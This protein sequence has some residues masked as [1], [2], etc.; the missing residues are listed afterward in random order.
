ML[1]NQ[2]HEIFKNSNLKEIINILETNGAKVRLV[3]GIVRDFY[4]NKKLN[5]I[6]DIDLVTNFDPKKVLEI[7]EKNNISAFLLNENYGTVCIKLSKHQYEITSLRSDIKN[8]GR[9]AKIQIHDDW[10]LD[11][12]RR[13]FTF[14]AI[15]LDIRGNKFDPFD[16]IKD[17]ENGIV[18]FIGDP[19]LRIQEDYLRIL[20]YVRF[21]A[22]YSK[23]NKNNII[24]NILK[25]YVSKI[26]LLSLE[27]ITKEIKL[28]FSLP[29]IKFLKALNVM[30]LSNIAYAIFGNK[31]KTDKLLKYIK[32]VNKVKYSP[33]SNWL[34]R[35]A[36]ITNESFQ[37]CENISLSKKEKFFW[38]DIRSEITHEQYKTLNSS[39]WKKGAILFKKQSLIKFILYSVNFNEP[40]YNRMLELKNYKEPLFPI[41]GEDLIKKGL[42]PSKEIGLSLEYL[43]S[44]WIQ[45][46]FSLN[47]DQL[48]DKLNNKIIFNH[49][50]KP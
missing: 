13:D 1:A 36:L 20:R 26:N 23:N 9:H 41:N 5:L 21:Y 22:I 34:I 19:N 11:A 16:G 35:I 18:K 10:D 42:K 45:S 48:I 2:I 33:K 38:E 3:G 29:Q 46:N 6:S 31:I 37:I 47:K 28:I 43:K 25:K 44:L 27:R 24:I 50:D 30:K 12:R 7:C 39:E 14:N 17:L 49:Y 4:L 8:Y 32:I 15:Y 40:N